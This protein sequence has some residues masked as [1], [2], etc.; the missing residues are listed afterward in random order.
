MNR[1][2]EPTHMISKSQLKQIIDIKFFITKNRFHS[3]HTNRFCV[4]QENIK[5]GVLKLGT[6]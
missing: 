6:H 4:E 2:T 5:P 1:A 3:K